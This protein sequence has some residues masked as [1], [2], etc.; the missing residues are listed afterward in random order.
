MEDEIYPASTII[1]NYPNPFNP[2]TTISFSITEN[3]DD[4]SIEIYN[5]LGQKV[6]QLRITNYELQKGSVDWNGKD[7]ENNPIGSGVYFYRLNVDGKMIDSRK[8]LLI[9]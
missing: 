1:G 5:V 3:V 9:K 6:K 2:T 7:E 8:M 4:A